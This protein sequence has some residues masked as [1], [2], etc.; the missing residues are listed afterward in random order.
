MSNLKNTKEQE[1]FWSLRYKEERTGWDIGYP[2]TPLKEYIDQL[3]KVLRIL[4][5]T[6][7]GGDPSHSKHGGWLTGAIGNFLQGS[8]EFYINRSCDRFLF[9]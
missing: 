8:D 3:E 5:E 7:L 9:T 4:K 1:A 2:S 6:C